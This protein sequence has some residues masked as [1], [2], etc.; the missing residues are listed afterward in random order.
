MSTKVNSKITEPTLYSIGHG[1]RG[2]ETFLALLQDH[3]I[4]FLA[5]VRSYPSSK[6]NPHFNQENLQRALNKADISYTWFPEL[7]GFRRT[8]LG[9][10]SPHVALKSTGFRNYADY[11]ATEPFRGGVDKLIRLAGLGPTCFMCAET[12]PH[13]CHRS[14]LSDYLLVQE[15]KVIHIVDSQRTLS[16]QLSPLATVIEGRLIYNRSEPQ[17]LELKTNDESEKSSEGSK[18]Y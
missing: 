5:D 6:R 17:Q 16:H 12:Q 2:S 14:L 13:R 18:H 8:G 1:N 4:K 9:N 10:E 11:M 15:F 3:G 7:G